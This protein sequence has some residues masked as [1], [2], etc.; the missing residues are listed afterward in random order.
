[1]KSL[2]LNL[3]TL[4]SVFT[5]NSTDLRKQT[6]VNQ[7]DLKS[8]DK[9][10]KEVTDLVNVLK[11]MQETC[12]SEVTQAKE[13]LL[14]H[15]EFKRKYESVMKVIGITKPLPVI[16]FQAMKA[17]SDEQTQRWRSLASKRQE[18]RVAVTSAA[19]KY[20]PAPP[21]DC[22]D[23]DTTPPCH[24][25]ISFSVSMLDHSL[26]SPVERYRESLGLLNIPESDNE[27]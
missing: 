20:S 27:D 11:K 17:T 25:D 13:R 26:F 5:V 14:N 3:T 2:F 8:S 18:T 1:M 12:D 4:L 24:P 9:L 10:C 22:N 7:H 19:A 6:V 21:K 16:E 15:P 23:N